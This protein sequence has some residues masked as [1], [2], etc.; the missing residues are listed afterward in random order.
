[1][2]SLH[3]DDGNAQETAKYEE[4][5]QI[6]DYREADSPGLFNVSRFCEILDPKVGESLIDVGCGSGKA[7]I[8]F[9]QCGLNVY[10]TDIVDTA[11]DPLVPRK[12]FIKRPLW[13]SWGQSYFDY[14]FCCDVMEHIPPEYTM[15]CLDRIVS[16]CGISY[17]QI[18][19]REDKFGQMIGEPLH[20]TVRPFEWWLVRLQTLGNVMDARDLCDD[21]LFIVKSRVLEREYD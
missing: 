18:A 1:M 17:F 15:L 12:K 11:L 10:W 7:G 6:E 3:I 13:W 4:I 20:L 21:G 9:E 8:A 2:T 14:G 5:W 19:L 16:H